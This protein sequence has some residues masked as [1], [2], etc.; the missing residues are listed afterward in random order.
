MV[1]WKV[2]MEISE[3][4][5]EYKKRIN[6]YEKLET[7][8]KFILEQK[9]SAAKIPYH[10]I[11]SRLKEFDSFTKK[12]H[13]METG[14][15]FE[16]IED[17][18]GIRII[19]LFL[20]DLQRIGEIIESNFNILK[21]DDKIY[22]Q[23]DAFGYLS[24]HYIGI[25][26]KIFSGPRYD[27]IHGLK[28]EIQLRTIAMHAWATI[29]HYIDYKSPLAIP[30]HLRKDF[31]ALSAMF[32][33]ADEHFEMFFKSSEEAKQLA[34]G[35]TFTLKTEMVEINYN[36]LVA[37]LLDK[38]KGRKHSSK[39]TVSDLIEEL[40]QSGYTTINQLDKILK[41]SKKA[42]EVCESE[43][44]PGDSGSGKYQDVGV[45]RVSLHI[46]DEKFLKMA[47]ISDSLK[48]ERRAYKS[49]VE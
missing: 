13:S 32:Y 46:A 24:V 9:L 26:P 14:K 19:C 40:Q 36:T 17:I 38:Y 31:N 47:K 20:S 18:C 41:K 6:N 44:P 3:L 11:T 16:D 5:E 42:F 7:E 39:Q 10:Q 43:H 48:E 4:Q 1:R 27:D 35:K 30:S 8:I 29:S 21:K 33:I 23:P 49:L 12:A 28:F 22:S 25:L 45:V 37:Y 2:N 15:P 34:E